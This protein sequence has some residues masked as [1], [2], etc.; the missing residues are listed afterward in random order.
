MLLAGYGHRP[1]AFRRRANRPQLTRDPVGTTMNQS[2]TRF[3][4]A[5]PSKRVVL[6]T[7]LS[8]LL[9]PL[10][11]S[12]AVGIGFLTA[13]A[14]VAGALI[15]MIVAR[16]F[17][18]GLQIRPDCSP[19]R[20][21]FDVSLHSRAPRRYK[22]WYMPLVGATTAGAACEALRGSADLLLAGAAIGALEGL[23]VALSLPLSWGL[24]AAIQRRRFGRAA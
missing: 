20:A 3:P 11:V 18:F 5:L 10:V 16:T 21:D 22:R 12:V 9:G 19:L 15:P 17:V 14:A 23:L 13:L 4:F 6:L 2:D 8:P 7:G 24:V 1:A